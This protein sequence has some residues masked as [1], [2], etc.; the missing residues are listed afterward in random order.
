MNAFK[1]EY[2]P[3]K[4]QRDAD[5]IQQ[6]MADETPVVVLDIVDDIFAYNSDLHGFHPNQVSP[7]DDFM[8]VDI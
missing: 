6:T 5:M 4:R 8:N 1:Q 2:D 7:T 3:A